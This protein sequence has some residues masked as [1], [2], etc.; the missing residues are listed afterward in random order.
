M[1]V[2]GG[3]AGAL[4][5]MRTVLAGLPAS[6]PAAIAVVL[7]RVPDMPSVL[8]GI[9]RRSTA[10]DVVDATDG[11]EARPGRVLVAPPDRNLVLEP[12]GAVSF[13]GGRPHF[14]ASALDPV[15]ES[16]ARVYDQR[17]VAVILSGGGDDGT[18][19]ARA[20]R[21]AGGVVVVQD[22]VTAGTQRMP[23]L[24]VA[25]GLADAVLPPREIADLLLRLAESGRAALP[26]IG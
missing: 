23:A 10:L 20:V 8:S 9:L 13:R 5:P 21:R 11:S 19:G 3:S 2:I 18:P 1:V 24:V 15:M 26:L 6:F 17:V 22:P 12:D 7:H 16:A 14:V 4:G 25:A